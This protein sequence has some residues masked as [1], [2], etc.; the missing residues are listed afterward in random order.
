MTGFDRRLVPAWGDMAAAHLKG[1]VE[2]AR[3]VEGK[4]CRI[5]RGSVLLSPIVRHKTLI[6]P[7]KKP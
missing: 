7:T 6:T 4:A 5:T 1:F 2:A 3:Y